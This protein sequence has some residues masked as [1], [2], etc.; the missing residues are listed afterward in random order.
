MQTREATHRRIGTR[1]TYFHRRTRFF[2]CI[3][4][5]KIIGYWK[6]II[7]LRQGCK[8]TTWRRL[9]AAV[10][11]T[12]PILPTLFG[13]FPAESTIPKSKR[14]GKRNIAKGPA[15][16]TPRTRDGKV[17]MAAPAPR[18]AVTTC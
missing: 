11:L 9:K 15:G 17:D 5:H 18:K 14:K 3:F 12:I 7:R 4:G 13:Q 6:W 16:E 2:K 8:L 1:K 10:A